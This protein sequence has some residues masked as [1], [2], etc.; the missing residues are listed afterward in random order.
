MLSSMVE[1]H[2]E[3]VPVSIYDEADISNWPAK[4]DIT[5]RLIQAMIHACK[6]EG[7]L[8]AWFSNKHQARKC[9][10]LKSI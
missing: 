8:N 2:Q 4:S 5:V 3:V 1:S 7:S 6:K 9:F 10:F